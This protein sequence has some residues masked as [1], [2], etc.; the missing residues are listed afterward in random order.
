[1]LEHDLFDPSGDFER[2]DNP[3]GIFIG[4]G[5]RAQYQQHRYA[6][7]ARGQNGPIACFFGEGS[8]M[9]GVLEDGSNDRSCVI[10]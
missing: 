2:L 1:M 6:E 7:I 5:R 3:R 8:E 10:A 9:I 4:S